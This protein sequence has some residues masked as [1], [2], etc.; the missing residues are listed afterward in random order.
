MFLQIFE[1]P[2][3]IIIGLERHIL[4]TI[5][6][7]FRT[8]YPQK[9]L[10]KVVRSVLGRQG[11]A[12]FYRLAYAMCT[13][14][15]K[16]FVPI[17]RTSLTMVLAIVELTARLRGNNDQLER[18]QSFA[19]RKAQYSR[20]AVTETMLDLLDLY[21]QHTKSTKVGAV[22][23]LNTFMDIKI[24]LNNELDR[25]LDPRYLYHCNRCEIEDVA[26]PTPRSATANTAELSTKRGQ[27]GTTRFVFDPDMAKTEQNI[28]EGYFNDEMEEYE[29]E[30]EEP[31]VPPPQ[32]PSRDAP[33]R[34]DGGSRGGTRGGY[35]G[36]HSW[37]SRGD[38]R[39]A[40]PYGGYRGDWS[41]RGRGRR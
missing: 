21:V 1:A 3:K 4:E 23:D 36:A 40:G 17:K 5:G 6:F 13:D 27:D 37:D 8:R 34:D 18:I 11:G 22:I 12:D 15:Y 19:E 20:A 33:R 24:F 32:H 10:V 39:R 14:M 30:V 31:I 2:S 9:L 35:R 28:V 16:T 41:G 25:S 7:D 26:P 38:P 29:I